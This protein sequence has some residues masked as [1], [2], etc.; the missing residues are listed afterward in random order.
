LLAGFAFFT[1]SLSG[2]A[3]R[4]FGIDQTVINVSPKPILLVWFSIFLFVVCK[5]TF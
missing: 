3:V 4:S 5:E 1:F 2:G